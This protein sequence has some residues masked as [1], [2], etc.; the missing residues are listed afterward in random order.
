VDNSKGTRPN[1][2]P[3]PSGARLADDDLGGNNGDDDDDD[4]GEGPP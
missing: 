1:V 3:K 2:V 4:D